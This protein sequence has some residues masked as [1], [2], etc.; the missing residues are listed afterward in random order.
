MV[1]N[2]KEEII[3]TRP[4]ADPRGREESEVVRSESDSGTVVVVL[5]VF[6]RTPDRNLDRVS[7]KVT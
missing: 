7:V 2:Y 6:R 4:I 5:H 3:L 1:Y